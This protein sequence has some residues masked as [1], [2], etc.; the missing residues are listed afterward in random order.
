MHAETHLLSVKRLKGL[1]LLVG[2]C[3][4]GLFLVFGISPKGYRTTVT[5]KLS[6]T[7]LADGSSSCLGTRVAGMA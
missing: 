7:P 4:K 6:K 1:R 2:F 3:K 5:K